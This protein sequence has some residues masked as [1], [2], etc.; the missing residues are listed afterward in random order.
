M[1][2]REEAEARGYDPADDTLGYAGSGRVQ[3]AI[4]KPLDP[5]LGDALKSAYAK[6][7]ARRAATPSMTEWYAQQARS[8]AFVE[9]HEG[10]GR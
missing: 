1:S 3:R 2:R 4:G 5:H 9:G 6:A 8:E 10:G 7:Q